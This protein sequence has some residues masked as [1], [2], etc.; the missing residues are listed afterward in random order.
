MEKLIRI[1]LLLGISV[2]FGANEL[3]CTSLINFISS[4]PVVSHYTTIV[5][6]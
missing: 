3:Q 4:F 6:V 1:S 5:Y 2:I